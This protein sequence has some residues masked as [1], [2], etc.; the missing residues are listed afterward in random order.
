MS[1][2]F[3]KTVRYLTLTSAL[4]SIAVA[5]PCY[6]QKDMTM[7]D[8]RV[9][10]RVERR[11]RPKEPDNFGI[12]SSDIFLNLYA[13]ATSGIFALLIGVVSLSIREVTAPA[14]ATV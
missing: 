5:S 14:E 8:A 9:A 7:D 1:Q 10:M 2:P 12:L 6:A 4:V 13:Q 3:Y 11:L